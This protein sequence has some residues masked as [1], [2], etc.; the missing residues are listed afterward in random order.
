MLTKVPDNY[1]FYMQRCS[2]NIHTYV[3]GDTLLNSKGKRAVC[4]EY[5]KCKNNEQ[6][7][8]LNEYF[9]TYIA[10]RYKDFLSYG[11]TNLNRGF[12]RTIPLP[13]FMK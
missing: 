8:Q 3:P 2:K 1:F 7:M 10:E 11:D 13:D 6:V 4:I 9:K 12:L 5:I